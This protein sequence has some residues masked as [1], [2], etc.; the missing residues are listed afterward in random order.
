MAAVADY[1]NHHRV[2]TRE[3]L[4]RLQALQWQATRQGWT[5]RQ[6]LGS[7]G[8]GLVGAATLP[9]IRSRPAAAAARSTRTS[10][11][12]VAIVGGGLAGLACA[13]RLEASG[14]IPVVYE[15]NT[16]VGGRCKSYRGFPVDKVAEAGGELID[17]LHKTML[18]YANELGLA[19]EDLSKA[20][21][22][23]AY[24]FFDALWSEADVIDQYR[25]FVGNMRDDLRRCSGAPTF[26]DH[27]DADVELDSLDLATYLDTRAEGL[28]LIRAVLDE[29]YVAEYGLECAEQS[30]LNMI[31][32][33]HA[34]SSSKFREFGIFSDE[35]YHIVDGNDRIPEGLADR[36]SAPLNTDARLTRLARNASGEYQLYFNGSSSPELADAVVIAIPF[37]VLR[38]IDLD[39]S[40]GLSTDKQR[41]INEL[42]YGTNCKTMILF[43]GRPWYDLH[44]SSGLAYSDLDNVQNTWETNYTSSAEIGMLT[45][46]AGGDRGRD[47]QVVG[48]GGYCSSCHVGPVA[49]LDIDPSLVQTQ[50]A[51]FLD[52]LERIWPG[53]R[54][55][56]KTAD[57]KLLAFRGHWLPQKWSKGS[58]TCYK[59]GQFTGIA[60][61]E[62]ESAGRLKFAGEHAN[63]FYEWQGFMEGACLSGIDAAESVLD[64]IRDGLI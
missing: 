49:D 57:G 2:S 43:D 14:V 38:G 31:L 12:R 24:W 45:D 19:K 55:R 9:L 25:V 42:G 16:R 32:F 27:S 29:A 18:G 56:A 60:G 15:G 51:A 34:D 20:P 44:G 8:A 26:Y 5:R 64:D 1:C 54:D 62:G 59:P 52:D 13:D 23:P 36:M 41:A 30:C 4:E 39:P 50:A 11:A 37:S 53:S 61:L 63:S 46:Y 33:I 58:Y 10:N 28:P 22:D 17:N 35:R 40:L 6:A 7:L 3:G 48:T 47:I 21:G